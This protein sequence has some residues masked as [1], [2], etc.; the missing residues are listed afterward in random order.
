MS[1][2]EVPFTVHPQKTSLPQRPCSIYQQ[3]AFSSPIQLS[4]ITFRN[5]YC[6]SI[7]VKQLQ[8]VN[9][10]RVWRTILKKP[11]MED[12]HYEDDAQNYHVIHS[13]QF[14]Q[15]YSPDDVIALRFYLVQPSP[16]WRS[17]GLRDVV[18]YALTSFNL[19][20]VPLSQSSTESKEP[21]VIIN[22]RMQNMVNVWKDF[23]SMFRPSSMSRTNS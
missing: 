10:K 20:R 11:L 23:D 1:Y 4:H 12:P 14:N 19:D 6:A 5:Y 3:I 21:D 2:V 16:N 9:E 17:F 22:T 13:S 8:R 15:K 7:S 18:C